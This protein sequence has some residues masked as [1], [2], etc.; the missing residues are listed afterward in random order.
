MV[1]NLASLTTL[2]FNQLIAERYPKY[3]SRMPTF[4]ARAW[5]VPTLD[6]AANAFLWR[7]LDA[8]KNSISMA[9][10]AYYS[11]NQI[12]HKSGSQ[13]QEMLF[14]KGVNWNDYTSSFK[15]G[16]YVRQ[17]KVSRRFTVE[18]IASLPPKHRA[19][20]EPDFVY[21]R[22][23]LDVLDLPPLASIANRV[24]VLFSGKPVVVRQ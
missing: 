8:T 12:D 21:E 9:A 3:T 23:E 2:R 11:A 24:E 19:R 4:D 14:Q 13:K 17:V 18:E 7:E 20:T 22:S 5:Q 16:T 10:R 6:E 1:S 15:R